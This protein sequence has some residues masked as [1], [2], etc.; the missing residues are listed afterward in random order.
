M[1]SVQIGDYEGA[2]KASV[3]TAIIAL[4]SSGLLMSWKS[5]WKYLF[6]SLIIIISIL[7]CL[8][9]TRGRLRE[10]FNTQGK[11]YYYDD[12]VKIVSRGVKYIIAYDEITSVDYYPQHRKQKGR[13]HPQEFINRYEVVINTRNNKSLRLS[14]PFGKYYPDFLHCGLNDLLVLTRNNMT[15]EAQSESSRATQKYDPNRDYIYRCV[16]YPTRD[17]EVMVARKN[18]H[19][20]KLNT[21]FMSFRFAPDRLILTDENGDEILSQKYSALNSL[22]LFEKYS[23]DSEKGKYAALRVV[24]YNYKYKDFILLNYKNTATINRKDFDKLAKAI[25]TANAFIKRMA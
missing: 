1:E 4:V 7:L 11:I 25:L 6:I 12:R 10:R 15:T 13:K 9:F 19:D 16:I 5:D 14:T 3:I 20:Q 8:L 24:Y 23:P 21:E 17:D 22:Y 2:R 18:P